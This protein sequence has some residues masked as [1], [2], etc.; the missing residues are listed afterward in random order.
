MIVYQQNNRRKG[1]IVRREA[2]GRGIRICGVYKEIFGRSDGGMIMGSVAKQSSPISNT[3][4]GCRLVKP[5]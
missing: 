5:L 1:D 4:E 2:W 3:A